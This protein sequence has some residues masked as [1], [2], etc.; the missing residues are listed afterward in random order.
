MAEAAPSPSFKMSQPDLLLELLIVAF[1]S[2][3]SRTF[4]RTFSSDHLALTQAG[5][6]KED[7]ETCGRIVRPFAMAARRANSPAFVS[8][9]LDLRLHAFLLALFKQALHVSDGRF[10]P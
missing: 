8:I 2:T 5:V 7:A 9:F 1:G 4:A 10:H 6:S 3:S